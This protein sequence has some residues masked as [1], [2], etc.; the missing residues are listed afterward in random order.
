VILDVVLA[1][2]AILTVYLIAR[3]RRIDARHFTQ[4]APGVFVRPKRRKKKRAPT[5]EA[6]SA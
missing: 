5:T 1:M 2:G 3:K 4:P 6:S